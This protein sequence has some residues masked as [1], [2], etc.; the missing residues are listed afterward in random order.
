MASLLLG[1]PPANHT[2]PLS[3]DLE[4]ELPKAVELAVSISLQCQLHQLAWF[5]HATWSFDF[6]HL[7]LLGL[8]G[9]FVTNFV[10][11]TSHVV[12]TAGYTIHH[13]CLSHVSIGPRNR[14][15]YRLYREVSKPTNTVLLTAGFKMQKLTF[16]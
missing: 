4:D 6:G 1:P 7:T 12:I 2:K 11:C 3:A 8:H 5:C 16:F 14:S 15:L 13:L 9:C 10:G